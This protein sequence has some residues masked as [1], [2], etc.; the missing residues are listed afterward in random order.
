MSRP[1]VRRLARRAALLAVLVAAASAHVGSPDVFFDGMAGPYAVRVLVRPPTV[2]PGLA[3]VTVRANGVNAADVA[4]AQVRAVFWSTGSKGSPRGEPLAR[5]EAPDPTFTGRL[6][7]MRNGAWTV[8]VRVD[9]RRG[10]G[11]VDVPVGAVATRVLGLT[12]LLKIALTA[13]GLFL[14][15][16]LLT[17]VHAGAGEALTTPGEAMSAARA[18]RARS[19]TTA[20]FAVLTLLVLGGAKWWDAEA[21]AYRRT[22][23]TPLAVHSIVRGD[24]AART[25]D[26]V[27][28]DSAWRAGFVSPFVPDHGKLAHL[29]L[30]RDADLGAFAHLHPAQPDSNTLAAPL[31]PLPAGRYRVYA[32]VVHESGFA[33]TLVDSV[34]VPASPAA[35]MPAHTGDEAW[36]VTPTAP[37]VA[38]GTTAVA[39]LEDGATLTWSGEVAPRAGRETTL[40]FVLRAPDGSPAV[41]EPYLGMAGHAVV[42]RRDGAVFVHLHPGGTVSAA[43]QRTFA[44]RDRG[45]T[46]AKG[47]LAPGTMDAMPAMTH[48][49]GSEIAFPYAFPSAGDYRVWVQLRRAGRVLTGAYDVRVDTATR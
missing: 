11:E 12:P 27:I 35:P 34:E 21:R 2:V 43:A 14:F 48:G 20:G 38:R 47:H 17:I 13:L 4:G 29:F 44:L 3:Y 9:G 31:P 24:G 40:R 45:D 28:T 41:P 1:F 42:T 37:R 6:W 15:F 26:V 18:R 22:L 16:G 49:W 30:V 46:T 19:I 25:L 8:R 5:V 36:A 33:R 10:A 23:Y 32:D 7:L 39:K